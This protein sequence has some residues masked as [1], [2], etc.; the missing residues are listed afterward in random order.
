MFDYKKK[1]KFGLLD[2]S[3][4]KTVPKSTH[5]ADNKLDIAEDKIR[6]LENLLIKIGPLLTT[7]QDNAKKEHDNQYLW[8]PL[9]DELVEDL[10][11]INLFNKEPKDISVVFSRDFLKTYTKNN[12]ISDKK[13]S[14][15]TGTN[16]TSSLINDKDQD[17]D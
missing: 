8:T 12:C 7:I 16:V 13:L 11:E 3:E 5:V 10:I 2:D 15:N 6:L 9:Y 4:K 14:K 17:G 1:Y